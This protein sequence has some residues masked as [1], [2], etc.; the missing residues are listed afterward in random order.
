MTFQQTQRPEQKEWG[1]LETNQLHILAAS[2]M[3][4]WNREYDQ[5]PA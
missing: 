1:I 5:L 3:E 2:T 4:K